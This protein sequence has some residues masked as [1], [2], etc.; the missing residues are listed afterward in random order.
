MKPPVADSAERAEVTS[1]V[2]VMGSAIESPP[3]GGGWDG[4]TTPPNVVA[5]QGGLGD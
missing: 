2:V 5:F 3:G 1:L 4:T